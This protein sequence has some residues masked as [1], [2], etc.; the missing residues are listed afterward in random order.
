MCNSTHVKL[1]CLFMFIIIIDYCE[2]LHTL[3][4]SIDVHKVN[5]LQR[6]FIDN[7]LK[8]IKNFSDGE[9]AYSM[10]GFT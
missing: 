3:L 4:Q 10:S 5:K 6:N 2:E 1:P 7:L 8:S 9:Q